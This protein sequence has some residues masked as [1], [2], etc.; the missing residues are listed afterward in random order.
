MQ[1]ALRSSAIASV[2]AVGAGLV[3]VTPVAPALPDIQVRSSDI[4]LAS[5]A[6][7]A[8]SSLGGALDAG[9][10]QVE[11]YVLDGGI[12]IGYAEFGLLSELST[13][14]DDI[15]ATALG[16]DVS[17]LANDALDTQWTVGVTNGFNDLI[18]LVNEIFPSS[19][20]MAAADAAAGL[21]ADTTSSTLGGLIDSGLQ[22][23]ETYI[24]DGVVALGYAEYGL[25]SELSTGLDGI[26][27]TALGA[28]V[29]TLADDAIDTQLTVAPITD[30]FNGLETLVADLGLNSISLGAGDAASAVAVDV[31]PNLTELV[32]TLF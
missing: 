22:Q 1:L 12:A 23:V 13:G 3:V 32:S 9:I 7:M 6:D 19:T 17:T 24:D 29:M 8:A 14:L 4:Q 28:D 21:A 26:G 5:V 10:Q 11:T 18:A 31:A 15:G 27:A 2:A 25:L 16:A 20:S 30:F